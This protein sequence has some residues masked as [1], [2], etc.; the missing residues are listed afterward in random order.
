MTTIGSLRPH[1]IMDAAV[2][3]A[4]CVEAEH[5]VAIDYEETVAAITA[6][7]LGNPNPETGKPH[8]RTSAEDAAKQTEQVRTIRLRKIEAERS[9][10]L[11]RA[12]YEV[13]KITAIYDAAKIAARADVIA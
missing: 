6:S 13:A 3:F 9:T 2:H 10:I 1:P 4:D 7:L 12:K 11:A 5:R 8:S